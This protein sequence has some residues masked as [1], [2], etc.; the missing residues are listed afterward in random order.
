MV[1]RITT[2]LLEL[3]FATSGFVIDVWKILIYDRFC[4][5]NLYCTFV[6]LFPVKIPVMVYR[7]RERE[8]EIV[9]PGRIDHKVKNSP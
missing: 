2:V 7:K 5:K 3:S 8:R 1:L 4:A 9:S 6:I